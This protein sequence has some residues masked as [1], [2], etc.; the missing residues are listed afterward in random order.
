MVNTSKEVEVQEQINL[1]LNNVR[2]SFPV[3]EQ[4]NEP[5][6]STSH[7]DENRDVRNVS[8]VRQPAVM[9]AAE[10]TPPDQTQGIVCEVEAS[11]A[12]VL[13]MQGRPASILNVDNSEQFESTHFMQTA[14]MDEDYLIV[15]AHVDKVLERR[16][17][18]GEFIDFAR[19]LPRD[20]VQMQQDNRVELVNHNGHLSC[21]LL[22]N[23]MQ[24]LSGLSRNG[25]KH[26]AYF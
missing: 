1:F 10:R 5:L 16:I 23:L 25:S 13:E 8:L 14:I 7:Q 9:R 3:S 18:N 15:A 4:Q 2:E 17:R 6:P 26:F 11:K 24:L 20:R 22:L 19:L 12:R 21:T